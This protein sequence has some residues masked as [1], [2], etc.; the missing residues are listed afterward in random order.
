MAQGM[1]HVYGRDSK[2]PNYTLSSYHNYL[3]DAMEC[4][5]VHT[6]T[7]VTVEFIE[8]KTKHVYIVF[9]M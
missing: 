5:A 1:Y 6:W 9:K 8:N 7:N 2:H 4:L 3:Q